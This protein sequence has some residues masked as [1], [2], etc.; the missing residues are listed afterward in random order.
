[1]PPGAALATTDSWVALH[2]YTKRVEELEARR[3]D[4]TL[5]RE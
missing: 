5:G 1:V 2:L 4:E 3:K